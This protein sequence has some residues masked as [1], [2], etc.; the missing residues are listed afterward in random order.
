MDCFDIDKAY[1]NHQVNIGWRLGKAVCPTS[2]AIRTLPGAGVRVGTLK[3]GA[4]CGLQSVRNPHRSPHP[5]PR[6]VEHDADG[7]A[8]VWIYARRNSKTGWVRQQDIAQLPPGSPDQPLI[9]PAGADFEIGNGHPA[10]KRKSGCG[11]RSK[12]R[13]IKTITRPYTYLRYS[14][15]GTAFHYLHRGD[16]VKVLIINDHLGSEFVEVVG[17]AGGATVGI[18]ARGWIITKLDG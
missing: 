15:H 6:G 9:G 4:G 13:P 16:K 17:L 14:A 10:H 2:T 18:G 12:R 11:R 3:A 5:D 8:Y 7:V 1:Q